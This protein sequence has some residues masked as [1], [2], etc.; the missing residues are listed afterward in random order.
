[1]SSTTQI[2]TNDI[3]KGY[4]TPDELAKQLHKAPRTIMKW[5]HQRI[6][7]PPTVFG[8]S[9]YY[10]IESV[11]AWLAS[12]ERRMPREIGRSKERRATA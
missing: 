3:L 11:R 10:S 7:P 9:V 5:R 2:P 12:H 8:Q 6:G 4:L 1:M